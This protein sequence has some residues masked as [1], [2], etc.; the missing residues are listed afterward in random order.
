MSGE[1]VRF[2]V[3]SMA[4]RLAKW[5]RILGFD[6]VYLKSGNPQELLTIA[7]KEGRIVLTRKSQPSDGWEPGDRPKV[8]I[9]RSEL[10]PE[11]I[12]QVVEE[13]GLSSKIRTF[14]RC[15]VCNAPLQ[16]VTREQAKGK[17][18]FFVYR[19]Q[20]SFGYCPK[21]ERYYWEGTHHKEIV[22]EMEKLGY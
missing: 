6:T 9:L 3:D 4:G 20:K 7:G 16:P 21:C 17:V 13:L 10:V 1:E 12:R 5:L 2:I 22:K 14:T 15:S 8:V 19:T 11:Q 18:P